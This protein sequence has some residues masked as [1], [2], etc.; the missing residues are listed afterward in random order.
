[1]V[2]SGL[3]YHSEFQAVVDLLLHLRPV[4]CSLL[5]DVK[6][7]LLGI[8]FVPSYLIHWIFIIELILAANYGSK[9]QFKHIQLY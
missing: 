9:Q 6:E 5:L 4:L 7:Y 3:L 1:M 8:G 2:K